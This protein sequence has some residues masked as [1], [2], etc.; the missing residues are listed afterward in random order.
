MERNTPPSFSRPGGSRVRSPPSIMGALRGTK[1]IGLSLV[2]VLSAVPPVL[3]RPSAEASASS[4]EP[5]AKAADSDRRPFTYDGTIGLALF[6]G[7][8]LST[9]LPGEIY[10]TPPS[11]LWCDG[12]RPN[13]VD[14]WARD[15]RWDRPCLA[16]N[17]S[18]AT[19]AAVG[20]VALV[21]MSHET[22]AHEWLVNAGAVLD[23]V[24]VTVM[25]TQVVKYAARRERPASST[26]HPDRAREDDRNL[27]FFSGHAAVAFAVVASARETA[28]LRGHPRN[29]WAWVGA[30]AAA[31]TSYLRVAGER[32][33]LTDVVAGAG[34]GYLVGRFVPRHF[35]RS[36]EAQPSP[37]PQGLSPPAPSAPAFSK[38]VGSNRDVLVQVGKGPGRSLQVAIHF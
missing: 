8:I 1:S 28:R 30:G 31:A 16:G 24:A 3:A 17:L 32:H 22:R 33:H 34:V 37:G 12:A 9:A 5:Q 25:L 6:G 15:A 23:S 38:F 36:V 14:R 7:A 11:C 2:L 27:S 35:H 21:P 18:Y 29:N 13:P 20:A 19:L 4:T 26:C 10:D